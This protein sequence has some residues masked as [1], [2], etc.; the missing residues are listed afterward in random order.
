VFAI[1]TLGSLRQEDLKFKASQSK[2]AN[3]CYKQ[4]ELILTDRHCTVLHK[5]TNVMPRH[6]RK[7]ESCSILTDNLDCEGMG[8]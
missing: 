7:V 4:E 8:M 6:I 1:P 2:E 5:A 3:F